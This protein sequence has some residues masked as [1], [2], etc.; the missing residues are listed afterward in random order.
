MYHL[1]IQTHFAAAHNLIHYQGD[2]ENLHGHNWKVE[3]TVGAHELDK[4]G[5]AIDFKILKR[6]TNLI[7]D[8]LD[9]KYLNEIKPF[10]EISPSSENISRFIFEKLTESLNN[11]NV[12]VERI[13]VWESDNACASYTAD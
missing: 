5:L 8:L 6:E 2:C 13:T 9:H 1:T 3:V 7:L 4:A 11:G 10:D 12:I